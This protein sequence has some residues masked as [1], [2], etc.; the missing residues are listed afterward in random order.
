[1]AQWRREFVEDRNKRA[2]KFYRFANEGPTI[3]MI[4]IVIFAVVQPF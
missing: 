4:G 1:M 3:L 2:Q